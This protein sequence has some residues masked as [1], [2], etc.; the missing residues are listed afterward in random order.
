MN[1]S[2][3]YRRSGFTLVELLVVILIIT[4]LSTF[5]FLAFSR[6]RAAANQVKTIEV[7]HQ[8]HLANTEYAIDHNGQY[9]PIVSKD[10][11]GAINMEWWRN[12]TFLSYVTG[13]S[14]YLEKDP[15]QTLTVPV[16]FLDPIVVR[17]KQRQW[18]RLSASFG[19]NSTGLTYPTNDT[20]V[21][22][23][24]RSN[25]ITD[26]P[27][28]AFL[29]TATDYT[30]NYAGRFLW[31]SKPVEGKTTDSK[32]AYRHNN[33]AIVVYYDGSTGLITYADIA[34]FDANGGNNNPFWRANY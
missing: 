11:G 34:R 31:K 2:K 17:A 30:V 5:S 28:T 12:P 25:Q 33:K 21:A 15:G 7:M 10:S 24:F 14:R 1:H 27:R 29:V 26:P 8:L 4:V 22:Y 23:C 32:M 3:H 19:F 18:D 16:E 20:S 9:V 13:D 6:M